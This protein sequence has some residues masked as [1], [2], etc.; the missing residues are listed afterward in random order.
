[1]LGYDREEYIGRNIADFHADEGAI[2]DILTRLTRGEKIEQY[3][4]RLRAKDGSVKHVLI[5]SSVW[6]QQGHFKHTRCFTSDI[7]EKNK[8]EGERAAALAKENEARKE[9]ETL[10]ELARTLAAELDLE[11]LT[12][13]VTD[14]ATELTGA[15]FGAFFYNVLDEQGESFLLYTLSGLP[16][17][18]FSGFGMPRN[19]PIFGPTFR[20]EGVVRIDDVIVDPRYG[21]VDPHRG[22]PSGHPP[23][24]SYLAAPVISRS[25]EVIGG[26]FFGHPAAGV[27]S[28]SDERMVVG[29]AAHAAVAVDNAR[30]YEDLLEARDQLEAK[31]EERTS[32]LSKMAGEL[33]E[34]VKERT[35]AETQVREILTR[36][37]SVQE[38]ERNR[39]AR[40]IHDGLGQHLTAIRINL[41]ALVTG[42]AEHD[43]IREQAE[44]VE[45]LA[46]EIDSTIDS[47]TWELRPADL[48]E[49][50]LAKALENLVTSWSRRF[51]LPADFRVIGIPDANVS[52]D[53]AVH[54]YRITQEALHNVYK[55]SEGTRA[56]VILK[57][58]KERLTLI[59]ED[60]GVG[61]SPNGS[62]D[63]NGG[64]KS[65]LGLISMRERAT[66]IRASLDIES[67]PNN[68]TT[69]FVK[70][71]L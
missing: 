48:T 24:R 42:C 16:K 8:M 22:M 11:V 2:D 30:L 54:L 31:V 40:N 34:E 23:V 36:L 56:G 32:R 28:E 47:V 5:T 65:S 19:T 1:M 61:F 64:A 39:I 69:V 35:V 71:P 20:G 62:K 33:M 29:L 45:R 60:D 63:P 26:L 66:L 12:Q 59:I 38:E 43:G 9:A 46:E 70:A 17:E 15:A 57:L 3:Q 7:T 52:N 53:A 21:Q 37:V 14:A 25:G 13:R 58:E 41:R 27:F 6:F 49:L 10:N 4:A 67:S 68:G 18:A 50:G 55:H 44:L 51:N